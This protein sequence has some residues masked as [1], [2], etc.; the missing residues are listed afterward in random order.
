[1]RSQ[2]AASVLK[3]HGFDNVVNLEGGIDAWQAEGLPVEKDA[4]E[5]AV[6]A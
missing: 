6:T 3:K 2:V 1:L 4:L 5:S